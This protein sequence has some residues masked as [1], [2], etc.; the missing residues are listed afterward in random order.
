M[1]RE[2]APL[3]AVSTVIAIMFYLVFRDLRGLRA[4][5]TSLHVHAPTGTPSAP[6]RKLAALDAADVDATA[7]ASDEADDELPE[8]EVR[9]TAPLAKPARRK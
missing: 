4:A 7:D 5:M 2:H 8:L 3:I 1:L 6:Q 9:N